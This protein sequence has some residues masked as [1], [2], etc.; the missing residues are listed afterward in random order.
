MQAQQSLAAV[1]VPL[2]AVVA[3][4]EL[5]LRPSRR[6]DFEAENRALGELVQAF[7]TSPRSVL[8]KVADIALDLCKAHSVGIS[9]LEDDCGEPV[10]RWLALA[11]EFAP[12]IGSTMPRAF[13]PCGTVLDSDAAYLWSRPA[14]HFP[15]MKSLTP[16]AE[17]VLMMPLH[18]GCRP[19]GTI[20]VVAHDDARHFDAEDA[21]L[22]ASLG[23]FAAA[24]CEVMASLQEFE[25]RLVEG[26]SAAALLVT[27]DC[28]KDRLMA[29]LGHELRNRLVPTKNAAE[30]LKHA[31]LDTATIQCMSG[32]IDRQVDGMTR[33]VD[34]L[35]DVARL[36]AGKLRL[37]PRA[38]SL[39]EVVERTIEVVRP[40]L[41]A[42]RHD[43][44]VDLPAE[45]LWLE[46]DVTWL[47]QALQNL[48]SNAAKYTEPGGRIGVKVRRDAAD[49][50]IT[51]SDTGIGILPTELDAI[52][53]L[54]MQIG[55]AGS[56]VAAGGL[57]IGLY[58]ARVVVEGHGG[59]I[60]A[61]SAG[62]GCGSEL[63][64]RLPCRAP[65]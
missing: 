49:A 60:R 34:D 7:A 11:G 45:P 65:R 53:D 58:L 48:I 9:M 29:I 15:C 59:S 62:L 3:T 41:A 64:V 4:A 24:A 8:Q 39:T 19:R 5:G 21:R 63:I 35:L 30:V 61:L 56:N 33:L 57:G 22:T 54:Y 17:E 1:P 10:F 32:I 51:V 55:P 25:T 31:R 42:R 16:I 52:F 6:P 18:L 50:V 26:H 44:A 27:A 47:S 13:S 46:A 2:L 12:Y 36:H 14:R 38:A 40:L 28:K 20:W 23:R 43:L 37:R